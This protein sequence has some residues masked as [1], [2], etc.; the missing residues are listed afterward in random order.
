MIGVWLE[1]KDAD[2]AKQ[3]LARAEAAVQDVP[4]TFYVI[5]AGMCIEQGIL[6]LAH[7]WLDRAIEKATP[8]VPVFMLI[9]EMLVMLGA[10]EMGHEYLER[11]IQAKQSVGL[12]Y[13]LR[14][15]LCAKDDDLETAERYWNEAE[16]V[17]RKERDSELEERVQFT[18]MMFST[19]QGLL[20]LLLNNPRLLDQEGPFGGMPFPFPGFF[21]EEEEDDDDDEFFI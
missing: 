4:S 5:Q 15:I 6:D 7:V 21:E 12:A 16:K 9:G 17:A 18:R 19:P 14:G 11:A 10:S 2:R 8:D 13:L 1:Q 20:S 3:I